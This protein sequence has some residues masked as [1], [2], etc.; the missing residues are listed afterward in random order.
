[1]REEQKMEQ[2][3]APR[4]KQYAH[5]SYVCQDSL[6]PGTGKS[7]P[8]N[9]T[10]QG[11]NAS[12]KHRPANTLW[13]R[14]E[15]KSTP[16]KVDDM[17]STSE[18]D[19]VIRSD[20]R[21]QSLWV[22]LDKVIGLPSLRDGNG[23]YIVRLQA[24]QPGER[25]LETNPVLGK[26]SQGR[27]RGEECSVRQ[28][29]KVSSAASKIRL[30]VHRLGESGRDSHLVGS[31]QIDTRNP[32]NHQVT[33]HQLRNRK[34]DPIN[35]SCRL[36]LLLPERKK[37]AAIERDKTAIADDSNKPGK[38]LHHDAERFTLKDGKRR[39]NLHSW[40][41]GHTD[42]QQYSGEETQHLNPCVTFD[43]A[44]DTKPGLHS[45]ASNMRD[46]L[47]NTQRRVQVEGGCRSDTLDPIEDDGDEEEW[48]EEEEE[49][50]DGEGDDEED[51]AITDDT[52]KE[53]SK[54]LTFK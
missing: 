1:L 28:Q 40:T 53:K 20:R 35:T 17:T 51:E 54:K 48:Y 39:D 16:D 24:N 49:E 37:S 31:C 30:S 25:E 34:D 4:Q 7:P 50:S 3:N 19:E 6:Q 36:R 10:S 2:R 42:S 52:L 8:I 5:R 18:V 13:S 45:S 11:R 41:R 32:A 46:A 12:Q 9:P 26:S 33:S 15:A 27:L 43:V 23:T 44:S 38:L 14:D 22:Q 29:L 47:S 21:P